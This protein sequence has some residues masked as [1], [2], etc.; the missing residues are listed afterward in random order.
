MG[1]IW[2]ICEI[3]NL[4]KSFDDSPRGAPALYALQV[5]GL[6]LAYSM[7]VFTDVSSTPTWAIMSQIVNAALILPV[8]SFLW[9][10][11][12]DD[13]VLPKRFR[14]Q[15]AYKW[16]LFVVFGIVCAYCVYGTIMTMVQG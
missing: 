13:Q 16:T 9:L 4:N 10:L 5:V 3:L 2:S 14:L 7:A 11:A 6:L 1:P 8:A 15:G 12:S